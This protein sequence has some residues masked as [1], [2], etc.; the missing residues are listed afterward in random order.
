MKSNLKKAGMKSGLSLC[1]RSFWIFIILFLAVIGAKYYTALGTRNLERR[2]NRVKDDLEAARKRLREERERQEH[3]GGEEELDEL[4]VRYMKELIND[5]QIR[6]TQGGESD[7]QTAG[8][9]DSSD[10]AAAV[11]RF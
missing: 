2:L 7:H 10:I 6:L 5:I 11:M 1:A 3:I 8:K 9:T 4:R